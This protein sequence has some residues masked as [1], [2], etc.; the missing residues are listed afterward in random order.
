LKILSVTQKEYAEV[1]TDEKV[2]PIYRRL[3]KGVWE[4][5]LGEAVQGGWIAYRFTEFLDEA[6]DIWMREQKNS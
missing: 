6:Y 5:F 4:H 2:F 1:E 3:E